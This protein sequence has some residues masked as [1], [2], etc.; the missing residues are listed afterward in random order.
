MEGLRAEALV[1]GK[2]GL[3]VPIDEI[4]NEG[5][6]VDGCDVIEMKHHVVVLCLVS[7][8]AQP[9]HKHARFAVTD[10]VNSEVRDILKHTGA[11][12]VM[13][14]EIVTS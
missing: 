12:R 13:A 14:P 6:L 3:L 4:N 8:L 2:G 7:L 11:C 10:H 5:F 1:T 9:A